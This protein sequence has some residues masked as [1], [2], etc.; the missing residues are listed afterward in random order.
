MSF[1]SEVSRDKRK[2]AHSLGSGRNAQRHPLHHYRELPRRGIDSYATCVTCSPGF[3]G[4]DDH[5]DCFYRNALLR[6]RAPAVTEDLV[7]DTLL[8]AVRSQEKFAGRSSER[9]W[10]VGIR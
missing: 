3:P 5:G 9:S 7:E 2:P 10:L 4:V 6:V 1:R 8:A